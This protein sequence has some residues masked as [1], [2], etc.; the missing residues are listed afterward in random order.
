MTLGE[1]LSKLRKANNITQEQLAYVLGVSRQSISK[2]ESDVAY[3]ETDKLI[4]MSEL[5]GCSLDYLLKNDCTDTTA[6]DKQNFAG[7]AATQKSISLNDAIR[8]LNVKKRSRKFVSTATMLCI[9][10][11]ICLLLLVA[12][13]EVQTSYVSEGMAVGIGL[14]VMLIFVATAVALFIYGG[15]NS[16]EFDFLEKEKFTVSQEI[17]EFAQSEKKAYFNAY[18]CVN[19]IA[20]VLCIIAVIL[21][22]LGLWLFENNAFLLFVMLSLLLVIVSV[23]V[24][25]FIYVGIPWSGIEKLLQEGDYTPEKKESRKLTD[26]VTTA[27]W[28]VVTAIYLISSFI[29]G[30]WQITWLV[31]VAAGLLFPIVIML[32]GSKNKK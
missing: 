17:N 9:L 16:G 22:F 3:P 28:L 29:T 21:L 24:F 10:S 26:V 14:S 2:W 1:K 6:P 31:W 13:T 23:A 25:M 18:T 11:P 8:F 27:Y 5:F 30:K 7:G 32:C 15:K 20:V 19:L 12:L 4:R